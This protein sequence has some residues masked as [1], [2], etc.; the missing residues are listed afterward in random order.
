ML[1][2]VSGHFVL[3]E[4]NFPHSL[5][6]PPR[7]RKTPHS[8]PINSIFSLPASCNKL[9]GRDTSPPLPA[10]ALVGVAE[11]TEASPCT[12]ATSLLTNDRLTLLTDDRLSSPLTDNRSTSPLAD[13]RPTSPCDPFRE[14]A[15]IRQD[16]DLWRERMVPTHSTYKYLSDSFNA[17]SDPMDRVLWREKM[18]ANAGRGQDICERVV[19]IG[20]R[21]PP[22]EIW[23]SQDLWRQAMAIMK[24]ILWF[25]ACVEA[26]VVALTGE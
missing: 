5:L 14:L 12:C 18:L 2:N 1:C 26:F 4:Q 17:M 23:A 9:I 8:T 16:T 13:D 19:R 21:Y 11:E 25:S 24:E 20:R 7:S 6:V 10:T 15:K 3:S 22:S